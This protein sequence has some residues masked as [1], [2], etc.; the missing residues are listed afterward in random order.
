[1]GV[2]LAHSCKCSN[3]RKTTYLYPIR[4]PF[5]IAICVTLAVLLAFSMQLWGKNKILVS[6]AIS[7]TPKFGCEQLQYKHLFAR[8]HIQ[9]GVQLSLRLA[10]RLTDTSKRQLV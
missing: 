9:V 2:Y 7:R 5:A 3:F 8:T 10:W 6:F 1:M 4:Q